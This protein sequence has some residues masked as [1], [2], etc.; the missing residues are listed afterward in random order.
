METNQK[1]ETQNT[2]LKV[3]LIEDN[4]ADC[5]LIR[6]MLSEGRGNTFNLEWAERLQAGLNRL[7]EGGASMWFC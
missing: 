2:I 3:L 4:P 5:R 7:G 1:C 6:E